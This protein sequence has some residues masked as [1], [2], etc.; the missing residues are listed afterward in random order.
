MRGL[1][2]EDCGIHRLLQPNNALDS[3]DLDANYFQHKPYLDSFNEQNGTNL[4]SAGAIHYEP[5]G[6]YAGTDSIPGRTTGQGGRT[7]AKRCE[8]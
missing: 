5:F 3:G 1:R 2:A 6:I 8:Q 7:G 4:V